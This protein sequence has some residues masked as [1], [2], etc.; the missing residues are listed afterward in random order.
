MKIQ[1][2]PQV[3][4]VQLW[5]KNF[6]QCFCW[7]GRS[8]FETTGPNNAHHCTG[9]QF[10]QAIGWANDVFLLAMKLLTSFWDVSKL[11]VHMAN[12]ALLESRC[13]KHQGKLSQP[14]NND[15]NQPMIVF[16][17]PPYCLT[18]TL[19]LLHAMQYSHFH[20]CSVNIKLLRR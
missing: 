6:S 4:Q 9:M 11:S 3:L 7:P 17:I 5:P 8:E 10:V 18:H 12:L 16:L 15:N 19:Q 13:Y 1:T 20:I 14:I 2:K